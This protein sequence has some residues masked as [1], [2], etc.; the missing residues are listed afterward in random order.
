MNVIR[1]TPFEIVSNFIRAAQCTMPD[2]DGR[3]ILCFMLSHFLFLTQL[4]NIRIHIY[5]IVLDS[6][7]INTEVFEEIVLLDGKIVSGLRPL[8][9]TAERSAILRIYKKHTFFR[10]F[11][12]QQPLVGQGLLIIEASRSHSD[13]PQSLGLL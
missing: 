7:T 1:R 8:R 6:I 9:L 12:A 13:T 5:F 2:V 10:F 3:I 11:M 4:M